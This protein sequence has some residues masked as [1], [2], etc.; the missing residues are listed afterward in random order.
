MLDQ[1]TSEQLSEWKAYESLE[2]F[3]DRRRDYQ[4]AQ[5]CLLI[6]NFAKS[7]ASGG[8][9]TPDSLEDFVFQ[10]LI[11]RFYDNEYDEDG[12]A[13]MVQKQQS[14]DDMKA[15]LQSIAKMFGRKKKVMVQ[16]PKQ[17]KT[18]KKK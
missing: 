15:I 7:F 3:G 2:P 18:R 14:V 1:L 12:E 6:S 10:N 5:I 4:T 17:P 9:K 16:K 8:N 11:D 13:P